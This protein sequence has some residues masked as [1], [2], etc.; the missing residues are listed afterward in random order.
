[1]KFIESLEAILEQT[2]A[3]LPVEEIEEEA[4]D[5]G[6]EDNCNHDGHDHPHY[7]EMTIREIELTNRED[8]GTAKGVPCE[9][10]THGKH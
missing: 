10:I 1:M 7:K 6:K 4:T 9:G 8:G 2:V 5:E 3:R